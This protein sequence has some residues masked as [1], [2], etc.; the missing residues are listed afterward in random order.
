MPALLG[1]RTVSEEEARAIFF[2]FDEDGSNSIDRE[3]LLVDSDFP[4]RR[5]PSKDHSKSSTLIRT[6]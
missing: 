6:V 2:S 5:S 3:E 4:S 1:R